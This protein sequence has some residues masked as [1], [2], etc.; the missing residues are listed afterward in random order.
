MN[1]K[2]FFTFSLILVLALSLAVSFVQAGPQKKDQK[3]DQKARTV[4]PADIKAMLEQGLATRQAKTD[5]PFN[6]IGHYILPA[7]G[8]YIAIFI[9]TIKNSDLEY[10]PVQSPTS[11]D[12]YQTDADIFFQVYHNNENAPKLIAENKA[13]S[14]FTTP[15][16]EYN[17]EGESYYYLGYPLPSGKYIL[18]A[19]LGNRKTKKLGTTY[20]EFEIPRFEDS[21]KGDQLL[22]SS[23]LVLKNYD[24]MD[25]PENYPNFHK[26]YFSWM[27]LK[28]YPYTQYRFKP[29]EQPTLMFMIYGN[30][31]D[32]NQRAQLEINF[33]IRKGDTKYVAFTPMTYESPF[34]EQPIPIPSSKQVKVTDD[35]GE[36]IE[37]QPLEAGGY[38]LVINIKDKLSNKSLEKRIPFELV[39]D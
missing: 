5:L 33:D 12:V 32:S 39:R 35:K 17:P 31:F 18:A 22:T 30:G 25:T 11:G 16:A 7:K 13:F 6:F 26:D 38:E 27:I 3:K 37:T 9:T 28:V 1:F 8:T 2:K 29:N 14:Q 21:Y 4:L 10:A 23:V 15:S 34:I 20:Y 19:A 24:Q 36:R